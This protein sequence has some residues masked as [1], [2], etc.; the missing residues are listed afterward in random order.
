MISVKMSLFANKEIW[1]V[2]VSCVRLFAT[3]WIVTCQAPL[4]KEFSR[5]EYW[6]G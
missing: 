6:S 5:Q 4:S 1:K 3:Q 2:K